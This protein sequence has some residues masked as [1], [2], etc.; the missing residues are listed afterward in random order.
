MAADGTIM[1]STDLDTEK[2][3]SAMGK[4]GGIVTKGAAVAVTALGAI[5]G[6]ALKVGS[7]FEKEMNNLSAITGMTEDEMKKVSDGV[8]QIALDTKTPLSDLSKNAKMVAEAG[9][10]IN[11][12]L[13]QMTHGA[14]LAKATQ[15][16]LGS[17]LDFLGSTMKTFGLEAENT[18]AVVDSFAYV[19]T[20]ANVELSQLGEAY[21]NVG[22]SAAT[23]GLGI[24]D[25]NSILVTFSNAGLKGGAAGTSLNA[26]LRNLATPTSK[27]A[28][29][30]E[31]LGIKLYDSN[32]QSREMFDIMGDLET[33]LGTMTDEQRNR[34]E[35]IIFDTV[36]L[37]GWNMIT[38]DGIDSIR[39]LSDEISDSIYAF[40][41]LGQAAGMAEK[42]NQGFQASL[43]EM[44]I[45]LTDIGVDIYDKFKEPLREATEFGIKA[46]RELSDSIKGG[47]LSESIDKI[48][49]GFVK[50]VNF[51][52]ELSA[53]VIPVLINVLG[54]LTDILSIV[55]DV[56]MK[57]I[58]IMAE[59]FMTPEIADRVGR[60]R[61]AITAFMQALANSEI[62][63]AATEAFGFL[64]SILINIV[65]TVI[66]PILNFFNK[67][68]SF[69]PLIGALVAAFLAF[70]A[71]LAIQAIITAVTTGITAASAV[72]A[73]Y[74]S[75]AQ[76]ATVA[77]LAMGTATKVLG[78]I[79]AV[80]TGQLSIATVAQALFNAVM[81][82]FPVM[83]LVAGI[84]ALVAGIA[85]LVLWLNRE[86]DEQKEIRKN[87]EALVESN[88]KLISSIEETG[89]AYE[90]KT[91]NIDVEYQ[92]SRN[93]LEMIDELSA[94]ENKSAEDKER[95]S[96]YIEMLNESMGE[97]V[98]MYDAE[99]DA[100]SNSTEEIYNR[101]T[102]FEEEAKVQ[103]AR[104]RGKEIQKE[105]LVLDEQ[106][107][108]VE[109]QRIELQDALANGVYKKGEN[110]K[111]YKAVVEELNKTEADLLNQQNDLNNS[112]KV[113]T[114][115]VIDSSK[116]QVDANKKIEECNKQLIDSSDDVVNSMLDA[117]NKQEE[118]AGERARVE[119]ELTDEMILQA[120]EQGLTLDE[121]KKNLEQLQKDEEEIIKERE[122]V[123]SSYTESATN[124]FNKISDETKYTIKDL[125]DNIE[126]NQSVI[127]KWSENIDKLAEE[128]IDKGLLKR[129]KDAGPESAALV[130]LLVDDQSD[131]LARLSKVFANGSEVAMAAMN[132]VLGL[133]ENV[134]AGSNLI[135]DIAE[136]MDKNP[137]L[138]NSA[139]DTIKNAKT[140]AIEQTKESRFDK[141]GEE[142]VNGVMDGIKDSE[143][144]VRSQIKD[145]ARAMVKD[146]ERELGISSPSKVFIKIGEL[147][148]QGLIDG[149]KNMYSKVSD[150]CK[151][152]SDLLIRWT[153]Q[154]LKMSSPSKVGIEIGENFALSLAE[155]IGSLSGKSAKA[156]EKMSKNVYDNA[157]LWIKD[158]KNSTE[159][160]AA[161]ELAMW[162]EM[163][164]HYT[165]ISKEKVE[166]DKNIAKLREQIAKEQAA[167]DY[168]NWQGY[169]KFVESRKELGLLT[170]QE[171]I[172]TWQR[173]VNSYVDGTKQ[174]EEAEKLLSKA[175]DELRK[176]EA[177]ALK[178]M[179][180]LEGEY[181]QALEKRVQAIYN[182][183]GLF[184][185]ANLQET[186]VDKNTEAVKKSKDAYD[187]AAE[188]VKKI[189]TTMADASITAEKYTELQN[190]LSEAQK[191]VTKTQGE[192]TKA[193]EQAAKTQAGV[194][195]E[196]LE[197]QIREMEIWEINI[198]NLAKKGL[199]EGLLEELRKMGPTANRYLEQLNNSSAEELDKLSLLYQEKHALARR[200][201][202]DELEGLRKDTDEKISKILAD[203]TV[204][205]SSKT[206]VI[207]T[208]MINGIIQGINANSYNLIDTIQ[209]L[210]NEVVDMAN[211][212]LDSNSPSRRFERVGKSI[213]EGFVIGLESMRNKIDNAIDDVF[214]NLDDIEFDLN[215][216]DAVSR[217][218][219]DKLAGALNAQV[220][221][222]NNNEIDRGITIN[223]YNESP[224]DSDMDLRVIARKL[225]EYI[226]F[227]VR[228]RGLAFA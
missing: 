86:T 216:N 185:E 218:P 188:E 88:N 109:K 95:L 180:K 201:A 39:K 85:L 8:R 31:R 126:Y 91:K 128:G 225:G 139:K 179:E 56:V 34:S 67:L 10:D 89:R 6:A 98:L 66:P 49:G 2:L 121:Y 165:D 195:V 166:I 46:L 15:T 173:S 73:L 62:I 24:D 131:E 172:E 107:A 80:M 38:S 137:S 132:K 141:I 115:T 101:I 122:R 57:V 70:K 27:A 48:A 194:M 59:R 210:M 217:I 53:Q 151:A 186:N 154:P 208:E 176:K 177:D 138:N 69:T 79:M 102:A 207:G 219:L 181:T 161:E 44:S 125:A 78:T 65:S 209:R 226:D 51:A 120:N 20:L 58:N 142:I 113:V 30:L 116:K 41:D 199:D 76:I 127:E 54:F 55:F 16:D 146:F 123:L 47:D 228:G 162:E 215:I 149:M 63:Q 19:T 60:V 224:I 159:Y 213:G 163:A 164:R 175:K 23:A 167:A 28:D 135:D 168:E 193:K 96:A 157:V 45:I 17:T 99:A 3:E 22:G 18:Q 108:A 36:A 156:A 50:L 100:L 203:L 81:A 92:A 211:V 189:K 155:G 171:E 197:A 204:Q 26:V 4:L 13:E 97:N 5:G 144:K 114:D 105:L 77:Q 87:T 196:N 82:A 134:D 118:I 119:K 183:F 148:M 214:G 110:D 32:G 152:S 143:G 72:M 25:V 145:L 184:A 103:A 192:L 190:K 198:K 11:L 7:D 35:A 94:I 206:Q 111:K 61:D 169:K 202:V 227:E 187:K 160:L 12:M 205:M 33:V 191:E 74:A 200:L 21:V 37:K 104:E 129:L 174:K 68:V 75:G 147:I 112:F 42:Q 150:T 170:L 14:N 52:M 71:A 212:T 29:E 40:D 153:K 133:P 136:G 93:L 178:E 124:M 130:Q 64:L 222:I 90:E 221:E 220:S 43:Q 223:F 83:L 158:Y 1:I 106:I 117:Y 182:T 140:A 84:A 9:G